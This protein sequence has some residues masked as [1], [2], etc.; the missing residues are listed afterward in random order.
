MG[1]NYSISG[2]LFCLLGMFGNET[3]VGLG[4]S[5]LFNHLLRRIYCGLMKTLWGRGRIK[6]V[7]LCDFCAKNVL[8]KLQVSFIYGLDAVLANRH[9]KLFNQKK[10]QKEEQ[11]LK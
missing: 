8:W 1:I 6:G 7:V 10:L 11:S 2:G 9:E 5:P 3:D 4:L